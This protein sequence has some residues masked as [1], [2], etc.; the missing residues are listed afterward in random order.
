MAV[1]GIEISKTAIKMARA[2]YGS[3]MLIFNGS[4]TDMPFDQMNMMVY[5]VML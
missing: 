1:T 2:H 5:F 3:D 4:V